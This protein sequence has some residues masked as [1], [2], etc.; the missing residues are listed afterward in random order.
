MISYSLR[1]NGDIKKSYPVYLVGRGLNREPGHL[2]D[3]FLRAS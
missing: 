1:I 2:A 3:R